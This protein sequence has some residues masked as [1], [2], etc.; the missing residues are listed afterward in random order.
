MGRQLPAAFEAASVR[1]RR[2]CVGHG[3]LAHRRGDLPSPKR[4]AA[5]GGT[6][7]AYDRTDDIA[8]WLNSA[9]GAHRP[10]GKNPEKKNASA[11]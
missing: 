9:Q 11:T 8:R 3:H 7:A 1:Y 10:V 2:N 5:M 6:S 4:T